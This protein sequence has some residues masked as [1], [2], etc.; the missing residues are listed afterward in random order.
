MCNGAERSGRQSRAGSLLDFRT[1][2]AEKC[3]WTDDLHLLWKSR[4]VRRTFAGAVESVLG[5]R[6][7]PV[8]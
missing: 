3:M 7:E 5:C 4:T 2:S 6:L 8:E 1:G